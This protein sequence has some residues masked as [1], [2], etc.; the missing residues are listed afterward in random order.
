VRTTAGCD[1]STSTTAAAGTSA[2]GGANASASGGVATTT[3]KTGAAP[4]GLVMQYVGN[5]VGLAAAAG[6]I[7]ALL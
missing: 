3:S 4:S 7:A 1:N 2:T 5:A 6:A